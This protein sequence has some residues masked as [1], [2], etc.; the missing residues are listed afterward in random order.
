MN[1]V[2][3][4]SLSLLPGIG[5]RTIQKIIQQI[6]DGFSSENQI[7]DILAQ[8][9]RKVHFS[10]DEITKS[11]GES[12]RILELSENQNIHSLTSFDNE[13][14]SSL[15][16]IDDPPFLL[17]YRG[18]ISILESARRV[19]IVGTRNPSEPGITEGKFITKY[20]TD[21]GFV[22]ISGLA[23]GCDT[24][25]H[26]TTIENG[27]RTVAFL[28]SGIDRIYPPENKELSERIVETGGVLISEYPVNT[29]VRKNHFIERDRLQSGCSQV[30]VVIETEINGGTMHTVNFAIKQ[31]RII[32]CLEFSTELEIPQNR[33]N[34]ELISNGKAIGL[35]MTGIENDNQ[36]LRICRS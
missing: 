1:S 34:M 27:G 36:L 32:R 13:F 5:R 22:I 35:K 4:L 12:K 7:S 24:V 19:A 8:T 2:Y 16:S 18:D 20:F 28:P 25:A 14:P 17:F 26:Q 15:K 30:V 21:R 23:K 29:V 6:P 11:I 10:K 33:G 9:P 31:N 3:L